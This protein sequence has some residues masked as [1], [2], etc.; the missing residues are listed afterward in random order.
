MHKPG[1][2]TRHMGF[3]F[4]GQSQEQR[5][6]VERKPEGWSW[7]W[8]WKPGERG[9]VPGSTPLCNPPFV[10]N[11]E[12]S[13]ADHYSASL[14]DTAWI[15][16]S[17]AWEYFNWTPLSIFNLTS[18]SFL[19]PV[20]PLSCWSLAAAF[21]LPPSFFTLRDPLPSL[22][23]REGS[24]AQWLAVLALWILIFPHWTQIL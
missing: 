22:L 18:V 23:W 1:T 4:Q 16:A 19:N 15:C 6:L 10:P 11:P 3:W 20:L 7:F 9:W 5:A 17:C 24:R 21:S 13:K 12:P 2:Q 8:V 14:V